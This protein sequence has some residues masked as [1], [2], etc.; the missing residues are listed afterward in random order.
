MRIHKRQF[1]HCTAGLSSIII[2]NIEKK[3][4]KASVS[5][6]FLQLTKRD[7]TDGWLL[8]TEKNGNLNH[9]QESAMNI[10]IR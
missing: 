10:F 6:V 2:F 1:L 5:T 7:V 9:I 8:C 4:K 3:K